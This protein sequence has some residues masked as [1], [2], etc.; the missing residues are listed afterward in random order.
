MTT[1]MSGHVASNDI[2][3]EHVARTGGEDAVE[4]GRR[5]RRSTSA[6]VASPPSPEHCDPSDAP[7]ATS[8]VTSTSSAEPAA[9]ARVR[10]GQVPPRTLHGGRSATPTLPPSPAR[11]RPFAGADPMTAAGVI[12]PVIPP[13]SANRATAH[14]GAVPLARERLP[15][16][17]LPPQRTSAVVYGAPAVGDRGR[18]AD[19]VVLRAW[20]GPPGHRCASAKR[21]ARSPLFRIQPVTTRS[22]DKVTC[23]SRPRCATDGAWRPVIAWCWPATPAGRTWPSTHLQRWIRCACREPRHRF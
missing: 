2:R 8:T 19:R 6:K 22:L 20:A 16:P 13:P 17:D 10:S 3:A 9:E 23:A 18:V 1:A 15:L 21:P 4:A 14:A 12:A 5:A 7:C 11:S